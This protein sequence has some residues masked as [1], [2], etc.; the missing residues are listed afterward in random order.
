P[1]FKREIY[2]RPL[3]ERA[4]KEPKYKANDALL[5][6]YRALS[7]TS[8]KLTPAELQEM[9]E[10]ALNRGMAIESERVLAPLAKAGS[11]DDR[12]KRLYAMAQDNAKADKAGGLAR[13]EAEAAS[14]PTGDAFAATGESYLT[15]GDYDKA[16][17]LL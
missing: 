2:W 5:D 17:E 8:V 15:A 12:T 4:K 16:I 6:V 10:Y 1:I 3:V 9:G 13:S 11:L 7:E 14:K